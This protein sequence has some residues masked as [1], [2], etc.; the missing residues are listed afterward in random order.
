M[1]ALTDLHTSTEVGQHS[2]REMRHGW[3]SSIV[4]TYDDDSSMSCRGNSGS[5]GALVHLPLPMMS[6]LRFAVR[7]EGIG[8]VK[9]T[10]NEVTVHQ[11]D[12]HRSPSRARPSAGRVGFERAE[13]FRLPAARAS[14]VQKC[15]LW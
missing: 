12:R 15:L 5:E 7:V 11:A 1:S 10:Q 2:C 4:S 9:L 8:I 13:I 3:A 14:S 6:S